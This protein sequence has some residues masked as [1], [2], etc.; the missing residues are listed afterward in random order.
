VSCSTSQACAWRTQPR[1]LPLQ[2]RAQHAWGHW[3][4]MHFTAPPSHRPLL[5]IPTPFPG[6]HLLPLSHA[7]LPAALPP[8]LPASVS[9]VIRSR[10]CTGWPCGK[11]STAV[12]ECTPSGANIA[13][14][15]ALLFTGTPAGEFLRKT[16]VVGLS[17]AAI[18]TVMLPCDAFSATGDARRWSRARR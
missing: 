18:P 5:P 8:R 16:A 7:V 14:R 17:A 10:R 9:A 4:Q 1:P 2:P 15:T 12:A 3:K 6:R 13:S 11:K